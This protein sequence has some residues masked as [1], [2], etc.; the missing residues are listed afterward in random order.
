MKKRIRRIVAE[1]CGDPRVGRPWTLGLAALATM[2]VV[3][4]ALAQTRPAAGPEGR[5]PQEQRQWQEQQKRQDLAMAGRRNVLKRML[6]PLREQV[7]EVERVLAE[8]PEGMGEEGQILRSER[9]ALREQIER[10]ERQLQNLDQGPMMPQPVGT[11]MARQAAEQAERL[12]DLRRRAEEIQGRLQGLEDK[13]GDEARAL[14]EELNG[15]REQIAGTERQI[16]ESRR[17]REVAKQER[18]R[19]ERGL[20]GEMGEP[21][22]ESL[23]RDPLRRMPEQNRQPGMEGLPPREVRPRGVEPRME[24]VP[25][26]GPRLD[27]PE[28][29]QGLQT[30]VA[31]LRGQVKG[32]NEKMLQMQRLLEQ[33][34][35]QRPEG[36]PMQETLERLL[37][38]NPELNPKPSPGDRQP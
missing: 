16:Q 33:L 28:A 6:E 2:A 15:V 36:N 21:R 27:R 7:R 24:L 32:L 9:E 8:R 10:L 5:P 35:Q 12:Q 30:Q 4:A 19:A 25:Q 3:G 20:R 14:R 29:G 23:Q 26:V 31:D 37:K 34:L 18:L 13:E 38:Q 17:Q 11:P 22:R 1:Q